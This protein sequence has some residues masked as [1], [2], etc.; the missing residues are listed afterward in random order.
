MFDVFFSTSD[1]AELSMT[2]LDGVIALCGEL[3]FDYDLD[4]RDTIEAV[5]SAKSALME[6]AWSDTDSRIWA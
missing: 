4:L 5:R 3:E 2:Q 1:L 6:L